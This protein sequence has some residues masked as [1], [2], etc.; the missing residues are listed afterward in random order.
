MPEPISAENLILDH[1]ESELVR[2]MVTEIDPDDET[3][4]TEL[5]AGKLQ[6][7]PTKDAGLNVLIYA[8]NEDLPSVLYSDNVQS[9]LTTPSV[10]EVG[11]GWFYMHHFGLRFILHF[12]GEKQRDIARRKAQVVL[13]RARWALSQMR[14]PTHP[15]TGVPKDDFDETILELQVEKFWLNEGGGPGHFIWRGWLY[16]G[17]LTEQS[18]RDL[19]TYFDPSVR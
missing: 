9:G 2:L 19:D 11:G 18:T 3:K 5:R 12:K 14:M 4:I 8:M 6:D 10:G 13:S 7:D 16:F 17:F 15:T 1:L